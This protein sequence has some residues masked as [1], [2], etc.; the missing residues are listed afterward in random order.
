M[1]KLMLGKEVRAIQDERGNEE[2]SV[3]ASTER[4]SHLVPELQVREPI[5][6]EST[7]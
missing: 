5:F 4:A 2:D 6:T 1:C 7:Q 3:K